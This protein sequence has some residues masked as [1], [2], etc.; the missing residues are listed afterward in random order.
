MALARMDAI[1]SEKRFII[2]T[3]SLSRISIAVSHAAE[4]II[5]LG[6]DSGIKPLR[7]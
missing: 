5:D 2:S 6:T 7:F 3:L 4:L 1:V